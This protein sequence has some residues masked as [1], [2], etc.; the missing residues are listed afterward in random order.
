[1]AN[2]LTKKPEL[3]A[4]QYDYGDDAG[5]GF[6]T[7][8]SS[9]MQI[10]RM[11]LLQALS[12]QVGALEG[13]KAGRFF[14]S[15]TETLCDSFF[16]VPSC[17]THTFV[18][19]KPREAGGGRVAEYA[20]STDFVREIVAT[21]EFGKLRTPAGNHLV[22]TVSQYGVLDDETPIVLSITSTKLSAWKKWN[23]RL[24][25]FKGPPRF[26]HLTRIGAVQVKNPKGTF[27]NLTFSPAMADMKASLLPPD[28]RRYLAAK[29]LYDLIQSGKARV[30][31]E[32]EQEE[33]F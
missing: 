2:E 18:E 7:R 32:P 24:V 1:M 8:D 27:F 19:W 31:E 23:T 33:V 12:P 4:A 21:G 15:V 6:E 11:S 3:A 5:A 13:A 26:A 17:H 22:E 25:F 20:P 16:F 14:N 28:D 30:A 29:A 10:P 9:E